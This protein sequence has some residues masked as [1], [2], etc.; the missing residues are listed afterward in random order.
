M[1]AETLYQL[2]VRAAKIL[3]E[4]I[5]NLLENSWPEP[6]AVSFF[7][8][9]TGE[10]LTTA[11]Y[12]L[13]PDV[14]QLSTLI[15]DCLSLNE[16]DFTLKLS[17]VENKDWV[18]HVQKNLK[19]VIAGRFFIHGSHDR[20]QA[21]SE[22]NTIEINAAQA[23][24]T[25]HHGT[26]RGCLQAISDLAKQLDPGSILDLG[27]GTGILAI[28]AKM[29]W[30]DARIIA[31]DIDPV[32]VEVA[33][34][35]I[36]LNINDANIKTLHANGLA[37]PRIADQAPF[38]L[39]IANILAKPLIDLAPSIANALCK[40]GYLILSGLLLDQYPKVAKAYEA[41]GLINTGHNEIDDWVTCSFAK[42]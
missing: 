17:W 41:T 15:Q 2:E 19:P 24:G 22:S 14:E 13:E 35:N 11:H 16:E 42:P 10:W 28:A 1:T 31:T 32:A 3:N 40:N 6:T 38:D 21:N 18:A 8:N 20:K 34:K 36:S 33:D 12:Q 5:S 30:P 39:I 7:E 4:K 37:S 9:K 29:C 25:A 23:F 26:T 27:T